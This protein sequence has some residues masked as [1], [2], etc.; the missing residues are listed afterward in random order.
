[1]KEALLYEKMNHQVVQCHL[2]H[3]GCVIK[4]G[5]MGI[6][7]VRENRSGQLFTHVDQKVIAQHID[8]IEK[9]PLFHFLPGTQ[10][11]SI[12]TVGCNFQCRFCQNASIAQMPR[13]RNMILGDFISPNQ[14]INDVLKAKCQTISFTYTEPTVYFE[15]ALETSKLARE[16]NIRTIFVSNGY[17][18]PEA[19]DMI[20]PYLNAANIDL[21]AFS[22]SFYQTYCKAK[23]SPVLDNLIYMKSKG[24]FIEITTLVIPGLNDDP[25]E[26]KDLA[27]FIVNSL[28]PDT[29]WH[30][31]R[32]HPT[33]QLTDRDITP[34]KTLQQAREIGIAEGLY[35]V[36]TGNVPG[37]NGESTFCQQCGNVVIERFGFS[38][39]RNNVKNGKC[40]YCGTSISII[41]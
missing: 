8:P 37:D 3:H 35:Y 18:S 30:V 32:F 31:S 2:C 24:I 5:S 28:G 41:S 17:M 12:A 40:P 20:A 6:C 29:P 25:K 26:L 10:S 1:M 4:P 15:L 16:N 36:F 22:N 13:D 14:I 39:R 33:Y 11:Y 21:K 34:V 9:K 27:Q 7:Q 19:I 38:I 23:L